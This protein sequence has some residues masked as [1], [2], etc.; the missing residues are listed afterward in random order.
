MQTPRLVG[1]K[2]ACENPALTPIGCANA[3]PISITLSH[4]ARLPSLQIIEA[5]F[6]DEIIGEFGGLVYNAVAHRHL[7]YLQLLLRCCTGNVASS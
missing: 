1:V 2:N 6:R 3:S 7:V 4:G 5:V